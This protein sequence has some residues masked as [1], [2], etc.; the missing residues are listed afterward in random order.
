[1]LRESHQAGSGP[2]LYG[3]LALSELRSGA[4][5][6]AEAHTVKALEKVRGHGAD[7]LN[8]A[9]RSMAQARQG[10]LQE[11][12][13]SLAEVTRTLEK[14]PNPR[15]YDNLIADILRREAEALLKEIERE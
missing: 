13:Q 2:W 3:A 12:R 5:A 9:V 7:G 4:F 1:M 14:V 6:D 11:A 15:H 10:K 8:L